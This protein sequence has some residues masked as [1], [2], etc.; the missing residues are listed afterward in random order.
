ML[1]VLGNEFN[2]ARYDAHYLDD[3]T[4]SKVV[5]TIL[6]ALINWWMLLDTILSRLLTY[7]F[8]STHQMATTSCWALSKL[9]NLL[10]MT[11]CGLFIIDGTFDTNLFKSL[12]DIHIRIS[13]I[14][15]STLLSVAW[16]RA[17]GGLFRKYIDEVVTA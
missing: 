17:V 12:L 2:H 5:V 1:I 13:L 15:H 11:S 16:A 4:T 10:L 3:P 14:L 8:P 6:A 7:C 9:V